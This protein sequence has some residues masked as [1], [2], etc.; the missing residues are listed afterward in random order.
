MYHFFPEHQIALKRF[1]NLLW[2]QATTKL[3]LITILV[4]LLDESFF[5]IYAE[6]QDN[7]S[8]KMLLSTR[9]RKKI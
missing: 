8:S 6:L 9:K 1:I 2:S 7:Y 5:L 4:I 3:F